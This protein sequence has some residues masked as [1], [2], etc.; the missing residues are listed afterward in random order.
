MKESL[1]IPNMD[2]IAKERSKLFDNIKQEA[3]DM[4]AHVAKFD[5]TFMSDTG[6]SL[7]VM[8]AIDK[9]YQRVRQDMIQAIAKL[10]HEFGHVRKNR[11]T[12]M[13]T[14]IDNI[15]KNHTTMADITDNITQVQTI[16]KSS[17]VV[18]DTIKSAFDDL[19]KKYQ[20]IVEQ[21]TA[22]IKAMV[23]W[24][25]HPDNI[26]SF[27][28]LEPTTHARIKAFSTN[29]K[30]SI[31]D[32]STWLITDITPPQPLL[33]PSSDISTISAVSNS[34]CESNVKPF[35]DFDSKLNLLDYEI[36]PIKTVTVKCWNE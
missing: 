6:C 14:V 24:Y 31:P 7:K 19:Q 30:Y 18:R 13:C 15:E 29:E 32:K 35:S 17:E 9:Q 21:D 27:E 16:A 22:T 11:D 36:Q 34:C 23:K 26:A 12:R 5:N 1:P 33:P 2:A 8:L 20:C 25:I 28:E 3:Q 10:D 4:D